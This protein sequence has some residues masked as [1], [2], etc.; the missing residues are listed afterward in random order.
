M[1]LPRLRRGELLSGHGAGYRRRHD[2]SAVDA[3]GAE[4]LRPF[5]KLPKC[6]SAALLVITRLSV[7]AGSNDSN[8]LAGRFRAVRPPLLVRCDNAREHIVVRSSARSL[9]V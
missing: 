9:V 3:I 6:A 4:K 5:R 2:R 8:T 1:S 7:S